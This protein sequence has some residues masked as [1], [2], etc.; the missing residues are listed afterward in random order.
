MRIQLSWFNAQ[1]AQRAQA[2]AAGEL[3]PAVPRDAATVI[4]VRDAPGGV[5]V[6]MLRRPDSMRFAAGAYVFP[7]G[8][9]DPADAQTPLGWDG[10]DEAVL[11]QALGAPADL[12]R[13]LVGAAVRETWEEAGLLV[14]ARPVR[15]RAAR[16]DGQAGQPAGL[17]WDED[18]A[19]L[20][21][22]Q[23]TLAEV[24]RRRGIEVQ[25]QALTFCARWI[26]PAAEPRRFDAR[27]FAA[28]LPDGQSESGPNAE[29]DH[30][31]WIRPDAALDAARRGDMTLLPPTATTLA[32][33]ASAGGVADVLGRPRDVVPVQPTLVS[34]DD[35]AWLEIPDHV[36]YPL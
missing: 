12:T 27:F 25:V 26:T 16:P 18:R 23:E 34:E 11:G 22:G 4:V 20:A 19:A 8:S 35:E 33:F 30:V 31:A 1:L 28:A 14:A 32:E 13:A 10:T 17:S 15:E 21:A 24:L 29:A 36:A 6:L 3:T 5:E 7:G 9:V 2:I